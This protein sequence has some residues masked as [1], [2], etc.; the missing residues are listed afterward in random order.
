MGKPTRWDSYALLFLITGF[1]MFF[2]N[3]VGGIRFLD[4]YAFC[5]N[6]ERAIVI[7]LRWSA[8]CVLSNVNPGDKLQSRARLLLGVFSEKRIQYK[9]CVDSPYNRHWT[10]EYRKMTGTLIFLPTL[11]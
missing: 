7:G 3:S 4:H 10:A 6:G 11:G 1:I 2:G 5:A 8:L 9:Y